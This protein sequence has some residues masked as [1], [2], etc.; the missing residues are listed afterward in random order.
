MATGTVVPVDHHDV[1]VGVLDQAV[2]EPHPQCARTDDEIVRLDLRSS[3][4]DQ[5][6]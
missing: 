3:A 4:H 1:G 5:G 6:I 2:D